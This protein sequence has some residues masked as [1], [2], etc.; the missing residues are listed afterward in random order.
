M[1]KSKGPNRPKGKFDP[2]KQL[3]FDFEYAKRCIIQDNAVMPL[4]VA[5]T[6]DMAIPISFAGSVDY[7]DETKRKH[8]SMARLICIAYA[9]NALAYIGEAWIAPAMPDEPEPQYPRVLPRDREDKREVIL[10]HMSWRD[11]NTEER[12]S[13]LA[14]G[15]IVRNEK[16]RCIRVDNEEYSK[17]T[18]LVAGNFSE[19]L[20]EEKPT[21]EERKAA[22]QMLGLLEKH[23]AAQMVDTSKKPN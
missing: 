3:H 17:Q 16:G 20:P 13:C 6:D 14:Q 4:F 19:I 15:E 18:T 22:R 11:P 7:G 1:P 12:F 21:E 2:H 23:G 8:Q 5:H 10:A 9:A